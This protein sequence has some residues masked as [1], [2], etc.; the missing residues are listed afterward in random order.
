MAS[1]RLS[2]VREW[3]E[4]EANLVLEAWEDNCLL[5]SVPTAEGMGEAR[6]YFVPDTAEPYVTE[7]QVRRFCTQTGIDAGD[8]MRRLD[9]DNGRV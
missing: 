4:E 8:M 2:V 1:Y 9:E 7:G 6:L 5:W 3:I